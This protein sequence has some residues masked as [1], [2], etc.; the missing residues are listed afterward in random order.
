[1]S[2]AWLGTGAVPCLA[3]PPAVAALAGCAA[4]GAP[5][6]LLSLTACGGPS[7]LPGQMGRGQRSPG[8]R[9]G[10]HLLQGGCPEATAAAAWQGAAEGV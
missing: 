10:S 1:M 9:A 4:L 5:G 2:N 6:W 7:G 3:S 8:W